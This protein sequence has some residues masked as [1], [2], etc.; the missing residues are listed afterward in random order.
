[1]WVT[2]AAVAAQE[3]PDVTIK[4]DVDVVSLFCS[5]RTKKGTFVTNLEKG[6]FSIFEEGKSQEIR[7]FARETDLPLTI[8][9]LVDVSKSQENL[10]EIEKH[11]AAQFFS[12]VLREKDMAFLISFGAAVELLQ[13]LTN[14]ARILRKGLND[15]RLN[16][17]VGGVLPSP[18]PTSRRPRGTLLHDA[19][20]L[21]ANEKLRREVG[22]KVVVLITDGVDQGSQVELGEAIE[23][24]Q[25]SDAIIYS[26][27]YVDPRYLMYGG[28]TDSALRKLAEETGGRV[29]SV[30]RRN[31]L[32]SIFQ[33][34]QEEMRSQY[35]IGYTPASANRDG[36]FRRVEIRTGN[37]EHKVLARKGYYAAKPEAR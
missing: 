13:D 16:A 10:I 20:Y 14:S 24:A 26:I 1:M 17:G 33:Q 6:D 37:K 23:A 3:P 25:K 2:L 21:A 5:V 4:L 31:T 8:G 29:F 36:G 32:D 35:A 11:A 7:Y 27:Y 34:I 9:L 15:L 28:Y 19:V 22:R 30:D 18:V 12:K